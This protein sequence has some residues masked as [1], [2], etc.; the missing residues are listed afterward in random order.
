[1]STPLRF[2]DLANLFFV[3]ENCDLRD[4]IAR[5][6]RRGLDGSG[7]FALRQNDVLRVSSRTLADTL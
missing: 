6:D 5:A 4:P 7:I 3:A 1:M 2:A